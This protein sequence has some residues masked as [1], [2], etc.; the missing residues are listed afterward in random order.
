MGARQ[1][2]SYRRVVFLFLVMAVA[3]LQG[4]RASLAAAGEST[5]VVIRVTPTMAIEPASVR[6]LVVVERDP[7]NRAMRIIADSATY[8]TS[9]EVSID[10]DRGP[11]VR[12]ILLRDLPAGEYTFTGEVIGERGRV[13]GEA[14]ARAVIA[15]R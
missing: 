6:I 8:F 4:S 5:H 9:S 14:H 1:Q 2:S 7:E 3:A 11:R 12:S 10:G 15:E 13:R